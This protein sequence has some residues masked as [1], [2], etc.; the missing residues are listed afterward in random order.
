VG[1]QM[2][3]FGWSKLS[4]KNEAAGLYMVSSTSGSR[5]SLTWRRLHERQ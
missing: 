2:S 4:R 5:D 3:S 1:S